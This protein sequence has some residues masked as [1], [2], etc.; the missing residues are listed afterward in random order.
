M[1]I[2]VDAGYRTE[3]AS[4][5][6]INAPF[7]F[8]FGTC[9]TGGGFAGPGTCTVT[10]SYT[11]TALTS[12]SG[13][14][15]V[16]ECPIAG[17]S[18]IPI[19]FTV[20]GTGV[21]AAAANP[22]SID[23]GNVPDQHD[24]E[25]GRDPHRRR[26]LPALAR[27]RHRDQRPVRLRVRHLLRLQRARHLQRDR[28]LHADR[29]LELE[30]RH[31]D[32]RVPDRGRQLHPD[33]PRGAGQRVQHR[34]GQ[35]GEHRLR[36]RAHQTTASRNI[37]VT[38]DAGYKLSLASGTGTSAPFSFSFATCTN[39]PGPGTCSVTETYAPTAISSSS[40]ALT[41]FEC[42]VAGGSCLPIDVAVQGAGVS[43][44]AASPA[45]IDFGNVPVNTTASRNIGVTVDAG[46]RLSLASGSGVS[47]PFSFA[48][49]ACANFPGPGSCTVSESYRPTAFSSSSGTLTLS[50]C[51]VAGGPCLPI[52]VAVRG[53]GV[54]AATATPASI[55]FGNVPLNTTVKRNISLKPDAGYRISTASGTGTSAP[56]SFS[57]GGCNNFAGP[58]SCTASE[59][60][61]PTSL[62]TSTG[63]LTVSECPIG[64]GTC[65]P[66]N[67]GVQG[68]GV[69]I[70]TSV[71]LSSSSNPSRSHHSVTFTAKVSGASGSGTPTGTVTFTDGSTTLGTDSLNGSGKATLKISSLGVGS[72]TIGAAYSGDATF[73]PSSASLTQTVKSTASMLNDLHGD[74][75][76]VG[77]GNRL[78]DTVELAQDAVAAGHTRAACRAMDVFIVQVRLLPRRELSHAQ[79]DDLIDQARQIQDATGC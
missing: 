33:P 47:A 7:S 68:T 72:H 21:S 41:I 20:Q 31:L 32:L 77:H 62:A 49:G 71:A 24:G 79:A 57:F 53:A 10:E 67:V 4:G 74:V 46:Y 50:E 76:G 73:A 17:G 51:P 48:F 39:F 11:P 27:L 35:P 66:I 70:A 78:S 12:S 55:D 75:E 6:G 22:A 59:S 45:S 9:G 63:T 58:G 61:K 56:F 34:R 36:Q 3:I 26:R 54:S 40:G 5:T 25:P 37:G 30:R 42:P 69:K 8:A 44:A 28:V 52:D 1:T 15:N 64:G 38:V 29:D 60:F 23:F 13:T 65:L 2:T 16:F 14:T 19:P 43:I 18:C